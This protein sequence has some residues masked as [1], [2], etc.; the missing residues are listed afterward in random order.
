MISEEKL[1]KLKREFSEV[2]VDFYLKELEKQIRRNWYEKLCYFSSK[3]I[4]IKVTNKK[5]AEDIIFSGLNTFP[6]EVYSLSIFLFLVSFLILIP[7]YFVFS[8]LGI[9][10]F[11]I[12]FGLAYLIYNY[13]SFRAQVNKIQTNN[14]AIK[15]VTYLVLYLEHNPNFEAAIEFASKKVRGI[16]SDD[17]KKIVWDLKIGRFSRLK[18]ALEF[19][20]PKWMKWNENFLRTL[21]LLSNVGYISSYEE[22]KNIL[23]KALDFVLTKNLEETKVYVEKVRGPVTMLFMF[24]LLMPSI[25]LIMFPMISVFMHF[26]VKPGY[27]IFGY[28]VVLPIINLYLIFRIISLRPGAFLIVDISKHPKLPPINYFYFGKKLVPII[29]LSVLTFLLIS[30]FGILH[31]LDFYSQYYELQE[32]GM[33]K[34]LEE[35]V[36]KENDIKNIGNLIASFLIPAGFGIAAYLYFYLNSFQRI[37]IRKEIKDIEEDLP[38]LLI[39]SGNFLESGYPIEKVIEKTLE[40]YERLGL[41]EKAGYKFFSALRERILKFG[42]NINLAIF[43]KGGLINYF[44]SAILEEVF[45]IL[46]DTTYKSV[47]S[48]GSIAKTIAK[49]LE[50]ISQVEFRLKELLSDVRGNLKMQAQFLIPIITGIVSSTGIF[51]INMLVVLGD[52]LGELEKSFGISGGFEDIINVLVGDFKKVIPLTVLQSVVGCYTIIAII[53]MSY[54]L[55]G[56]ESGFDRVARDYEIAENLKFGLI[57]YFIMGILSLVVFSQIA[58]Q[59]GS[60]MKLD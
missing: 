17:L 4:P 16:L 25:G 41:K 47:K 49:Y 7:I 11:A 40:E 22:R 32:L 5:L 23:S 34:K 43:G 55:S 21:I 12:P 59:I 44:P 27:L 9:F 19:Y 3:I 2:Y 60:G 38:N 26:S 51:I 30:F 1:Q 20:A 36:K 48:A 35:L 28:L 33:V 24:G 18:D 29:P 14:E 46:V 50:N 42:E 39:T 10:I 53:L 58:S 8:D 56:V 15:I 13:P 45:R 54:L 52:F 57:I 37:K 6:H 31:F